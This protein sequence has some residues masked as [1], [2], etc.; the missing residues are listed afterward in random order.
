MGGGRINK[1]SK[2]PPL[3][4]APL[5]ANRAPRDKRVKVEAGRVG[6]G[7][8]IPPRRVAFFK[9]LWG[10]AVLDYGDW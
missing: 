7:E 2:D 4:Q 9:V 5:C 6:A 8:V 3:P 1:Q 10:F